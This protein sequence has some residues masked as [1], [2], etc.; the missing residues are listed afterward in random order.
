MVLYVDDLLGVCNKNSV[1]KEFWKQLASTFKI[2]DLGKP[3][4]FLGIEI[5]YLPREKCVALSQQRYI[6]EL[7]KKFSIPAELRPV[8]PIRSDYY[9]QLFTAIDQPVITELPYRELVGALIFVMVCTRPDITFAESCLTQYFSAPRA[10]RWEQ[11]LRCL[12]YLMGKSEYGIL[13][14]AGGPEELR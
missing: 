2:R 14:G 12:G 1:L 5:K 11:A 8:T 4:N 9:V 3:T 7:A 6:L 13:L 10:L